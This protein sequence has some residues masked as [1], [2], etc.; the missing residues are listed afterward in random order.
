LGWEIALSSSTNSWILVYGE[1]CVL[2]AMRLSSASCS[3]FLLLYSARSNSY[4]AQ[5]SLSYQA[6]RR[7]PCFILFILS[8]ACFWLLVSLSCPW[9]KGDILDSDSCNDLMLSVS[10]G[11]NGDRGWWTM[12]TSCVWSILLLMPVSILSELL[13]T[14]VEVLVS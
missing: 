10:G 12:N 2:P 8:L 5:A 4:L 7:R 1:F 13:R 11:T 9:A 6:R 14:S 3:D